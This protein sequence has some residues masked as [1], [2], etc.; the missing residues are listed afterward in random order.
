MYIC[1]CICMCKESRASCTLGGFFR[2][3]L[4][5][6]AQLSSQAWRLE[7]HMWVIIHIYCLT[8]TRSSPSRRS[9]CLCASLYSLYQG[10]KDPIGN[11]SF[12][13][14][15]PLEGYI[16]IFYNYKTRIRTRKVNAD[17]N[18][19]NVSPTLLFFIDLTCI[20]TGP[21]FLMDICRPL[22]SWCLRSSS[23][24]RKRLSWPPLL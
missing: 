18:S 23:F 19:H 11:V 9:G 4:C 1:V 14:N 10:T 2:M 7:G 8:E 20:L 15:Q 13:S 12:P 21:K 16:L 5:Y 22:A 17:Q 3:L 6:I 24:Y